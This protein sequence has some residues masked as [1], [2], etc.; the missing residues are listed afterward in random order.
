MKE[1]TPYG[2]AVDVPADPGQARRLAHQLREQGRLDAA[3][4]VML[5]LGRQHV[6]APAVVF[7]CVQFIKQCGRHAEAAELCELQLASGVASPPLHMLAGSVEHELGHFDKARTHYLAALGAGVNLNEWFAL[8]ALSNTQRYADADHPDFALFESQL[9]LPALTPRARASILFALGKACDDVADYARAA[10]ALREANALVKGGVSWSRTAWQRFVESQLA[11]PPVPTAMATTAGCVPVFIVGMVRSGTTLVADRLGRRPGV[12]NR[13]E[14]PF[15][16]HL[17]QRLIQQGLTRDP[18]ALEH[19]RQI[20]LAHL[21]QDD[22][23]AHWYVDKHPLNFR[24]LDQLAMLFPQ[25]RVIY[26]R[27]DRRDNA[28]SIWSQL[29][30]HSDNDYAY[31]FDDIAGYVAGCERLMAHWQGTLAL[32][33]HIVDYERMVGEPEATLAGIDR[34]IGLPDTGET[35]DA[36]AAAAAISSAS[37]W[38]ARQPIYHR[39][40]GRWRD[41]APFVPELIDKF[42]ARDA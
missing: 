31:D 42:A 5:A 7:D 37:M 33:I 25:A 19:A 41:Y 26:C 11:A 16:A 3:S 12:R 13:G 17:A 35:G 36:T 1:R 4:T 10:Q 27:R 22:A 39:S 29:F 23:P 2:Q 20:Y 30:A 40:A 14:L 15:I 6:G 21:C 8:Q 34:F 32:P 28:L 38:Q 24:Y 18:A 9:R